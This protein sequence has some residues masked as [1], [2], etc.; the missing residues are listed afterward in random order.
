MDKKEKDALRMC[1]SDS[2]GDK[3]GEEEEEEEMMGEVVEKRSLCG[4]AEWG[5]DC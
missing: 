2:K 3:E 5:D 1:G 4:W